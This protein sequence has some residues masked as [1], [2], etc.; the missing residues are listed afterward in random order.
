MIRKFSGQEWFSIREQVDP[1]TITAIIDAM[2]GGRQVQALEHDFDQLHN[3]V[4]AAAQSLG[5]QADS[6]LTIAVVQRVQPGGV[7]PKGTQQPYQQ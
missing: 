4:M 5:I 6:N 7:D 3:A 2:G 1:N